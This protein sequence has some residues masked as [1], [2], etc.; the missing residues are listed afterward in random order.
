MKALMKIGRTSK[1]LDTR[2][3]AIFWLGQ[4]AKSDDVIQFLESVVREDADPEV[5]KRAVGALVH[6]PQNLGV[7]ALINLAKSHPDYTIRR[8]AIFWLGQSKDPRAMEALVDIVNE[9]NE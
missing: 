3:V 8:E 9:M 2:R 5:R 6:A 7:P 4:Q 1:D